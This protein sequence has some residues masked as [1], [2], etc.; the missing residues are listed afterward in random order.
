[1]GPSVSRPEAPAIFNEYDLAVSPGI[2][3]D[4]DIPVGQP[5]DWHSTNNPRSPDYNY[6]DLYRTS[7]KSPRDQLSGVDLNN[8]NEFNAV[9]RVN[10]DD[11]ATACRGLPT[12]GGGNAPLE[13]LSPG[14]KV[15]LRTHDAR[16]AMLTITRMPADRTTVLLLHVTVLPN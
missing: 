12:H 7:P 6:L 3:Y 5:S 16:W 9:H 2:G 8:T 4:L 15:C 11:P 13:F 10:A 1:A 14:S